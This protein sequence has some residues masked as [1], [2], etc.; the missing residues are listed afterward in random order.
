MS[1]SRNSL[2]DVVDWYGG[3]GYPGGSRIDN[4]LRMIVPSDRA[5][6]VVVDVVVSLGDCDNMRY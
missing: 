3:G 5:V 1:T 6:V 4:D 2:I